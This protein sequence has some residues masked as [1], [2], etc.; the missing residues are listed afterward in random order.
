MA[1]GLAAAVGARSPDHAEDLVSF[2]RD[3]R[4]I[5]EDSCFECHGPDAEPFRGGLMMDGL[6]ALLTGGDRGPSLVL[7]DPEKSLLIELVRGEHEELAMPP[8]DPLSEVA[9]DVLVRWVEQ[10][11]EWPGGSTVTPDRRDVDISRGREWWAFRP[12]ERP[13]PPVVKDRVLASLV[14]NDVDRFVYARLDQEG[15]PAAPREEERRL[16]RRLYIDLTGVQPSFREVQDYL[17]D[18]RA[19]K[20]TRKIDELLASPRYG[21]RWGRHWLDVVRF[22]QTNGY[23]RDHEKPYLW[24]Y[25]DYVIEAFNQDMPYDQFLQEQLAGDELDNTTND[26]L[27]ATGFYHLGSW[28]SEPNDREQALFDGYDDV[29]RT[30]S[31]GLLGVTIGCARCHDHRTDPF[32]QEDYYSLLSFLRGVEPYRNPEF[33]LESKMHRLLGDSAFL[34]RFWEEQRQKRATELEQERERLYSWLMSSYLSTESGA[35]SLGS[36]PPSDLSEATSAPGREKARELD[37][38]MR[39]SLSIED[40]LE[41]FLIEN[42]CEKIKT[43]FTGDLNWGICVSEVGAEAPLTQVHRRGITR[44]PGKQVEPQFPLVMCTSDEAALPVITPRGIESTGRRLALARWISSPTHPT[45]ARVFVNRLWQG[46]FGHGLVRTPNDFGVNGSKPSHPELLDWLAAEFVEGGWSVK[47]LHR[48]ILESAV[49]RESSNFQD[50]RAERVDPENLLLWKHDLRRLDAESLRDS[51]L[52]ASGELNSK[53]GGRGFFPALEREALAGASRPGMGWELSPEAERNRRSVYAFVKR[54]L[55]VPFWSI[56]DFADPATSQGKRNATTVVSQALTLLNGEF[57][58]RLAFAMASSIRAEWQTDREGTVRE[59]YRDVLLREPTE[60]ELEFC[61]DFLVRQAASFEALP[62]VLTIGQAVPRRVDN[63]Y[64]R[65]LPDKALLDGPEEGWHCHRGVWGNG[66]NMTMEADAERG[67]A[68]LLDT[69][70]LANGRVQFAMNLSEGCERA[71]FLV[72]AEEAGN[73]LLGLQI[74]FDAVQQE[75]RLLQLKAHE[76]TMILARASCELPALVDREVGVEFYLN[77]LRVWVDHQCVI[78][79]D[80]VALSE[81]AGHFG[82]RVVGGAVHLRGLT[83]QSAGERHDIGLGAVVNPELRALALLCSTLFS[84]NEFLY[85]E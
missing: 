34:R 21:E 17:T 46:H 13:T 79:L 41:L 76:E 72:R 16:L 67:P 5:L 10:G 6:G 42:E 12:V 31:E 55:L 25:R 81:V 61:L 71:S 24:R 26:S 59:V 35:A 73:E 7:G 30:V 2:E 18:Q 69:P 19:D 65:G 3:V 50:P 58:N 60:S 14:C 75:V 39:R 44:S 77:E 36:T 48:M 23:E 74:E 20:W 32:R 43:S 57:A 40:R 82:V 45:T 80:D 29:L 62:L 28:D 64:L 66:Y 33:N 49:Y 84:L 83:L 11:A 85:V 63:G 22:A 4:P 68:L 54:G 56:F 15:L 9:V 47:A 78:A 27:I 1:C 52:K 8:D 70:R 38:L 53:T 51:M 37:S